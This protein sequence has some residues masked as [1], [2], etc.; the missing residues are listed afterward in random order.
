MISLAINHV[1]SVMAFLNFTTK[2]EFMAIVYSS[3]DTVRLTN[4]KDAPS[5]LSLIESFG[6]NKIQGRESIE[7]AITLNGITYRFID[8]ETDTTIYISFSNPV[9]LG[10]GISYMLNK[11][12]FS[13]SKK[14][15]HR[16][17]HQPAFI[18]YHGSG[19]PHVENY[20]IYGQTPALTMIDGKEYSYLTTV[21]STRTTKDYF[22]KK[23][24]WHA[25]QYRLNNKTMTPLQ[26]TYY[27]DSFP[28]SFME[29]HALKRLYPELARLV[30]YDRINLNKSL[31]PEEMTLLEM[32]MF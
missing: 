2:E 30:G 5:E 14:V 11:H 18:S 26:V 12:F 1:E 13:T 31:T 4:S 29:F 9:K 32:I 28:T 7:H 24:K 27:N 3:N 15:Y 6:F 25:T 22:F 23:Q 21:K 8:E 20:A 17:N 16:D 10:T 19:K